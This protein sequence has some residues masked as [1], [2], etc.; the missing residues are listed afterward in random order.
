MTE[1]LFNFDLEDARAQHDK[2]SQKIR[3]ADHAYY[4]DDAPSLTDAQ[5]DALRQELEQLEEKFPQLITQNSPTQT[6]GVAPNS[7]FTK[8]QHTI[9]MLS[10]S[11]V[12]NEETSMIS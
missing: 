12:F 4:H 10:L 2:L 7:S 11:N 8:V 1:S 5:Y 6:V 9:P 3:T